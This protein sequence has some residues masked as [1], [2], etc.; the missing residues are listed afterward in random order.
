MCIR[1]SSSNGTKPFQIGIYGKGGIGKSTVTAN[2]TS[3]L[4]KMGKK[5][6][7][8]GC[9][10]KSDST[11]L[12]LEG[13]KQTPILEILKEK[14]VNDID[15]KDFMEYGYENVCCTESGGPQAG[16]GLSLIHI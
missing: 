11:K 10:P 1:D 4:G 7:Q 15:I 14:S 6:L 9:D 3:G 8:I 5:V 13:K 16:V 12:L 2:L